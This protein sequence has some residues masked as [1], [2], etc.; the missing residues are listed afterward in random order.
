[1]KQQINNKSIMEKARRMVESFSLSCACP[2]AHETIM[3]NN[4]K[5]LKISTTVKIAVV[6]Q[7]A[8]CTVVSQPD[9][10]A[11]HSELVGGYCNSFLQ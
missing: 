8:R 10:A 5:D 6:L 4:N 3:M 7:S 11:G 1:M 2:K 9:L